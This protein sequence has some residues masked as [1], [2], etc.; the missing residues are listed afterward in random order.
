MVDRKQE[1][2]VDVGILVEHEGVGF[3]LT[4]F[5]GAAWNNVIWAWY[6]QDLQL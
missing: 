1:D 6:N 4:S 3:D 5:S 2:L